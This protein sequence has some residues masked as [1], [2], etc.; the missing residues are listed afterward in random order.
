MPS[1]ITHNYA[2]SGTA[3]HIF[4]AMTAAVAALTFSSGASAD[5]F[6]LSAGG[7]YM[8]DS[9]DTELAF[10]MATVRGTYYFTETWALKPK[11]HLV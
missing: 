1:S 2:L 3:P 11:V 5:D 10:T 8:F 6:Q 9:S 4:I 7:T